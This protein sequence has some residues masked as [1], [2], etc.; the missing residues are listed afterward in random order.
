M[1]GAIKG[2]DLS[3]NRPR[4]SNDRKKHG[5]KILSP[6]ERKDLDVRS[7]WSSFSNEKKKEWLTISVSDIN[8][9]FLLIKEVFASEVISEAVEYADANK[10]WNFWI[11]SRWKPIDAPA[12]QRILGN[13]QNFQ[14]LDA[15]GLSSLRQKSHGFEDAPFAWDSSTENDDAGNSFNGGLTAAEINDLV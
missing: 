7:Y 10:T 6:T 5:K 12:L 8:A 14:D 1:I 2:F 13:W 3:G 11:C 9:H 4:S 15:A